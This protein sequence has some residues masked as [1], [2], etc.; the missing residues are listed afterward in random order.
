MNKCYIISRSQ[1]SLNLKI[2]MVD[3]IEEAKKV[4]HLNRHKYVDSIYLNLDDLKQLS[5]MVENN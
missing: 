2:E 3:S 4:Q 1:V 5:E